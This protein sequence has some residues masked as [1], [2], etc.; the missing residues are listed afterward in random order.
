MAARRGANL[1]P[2]PGSSP[3]Q[4]AFLLLLR[5]LDQEKAYA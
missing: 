3:A 4:Q 1:D 2:D 5:W